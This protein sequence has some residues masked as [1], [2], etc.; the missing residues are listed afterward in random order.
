MS[1][2]KQTAIAWAMV[3]AWAGFIFYMSAQSGSEL[4][5]LDGILGEIKQW[6]E[7][8]QLALFGPDADLISSTAHFLE[9]TVLGALL[10]RAIGLS[11]RATRVGEHDG[12]RGADSSGTPSGERIVNPDETLR[13]GAKGKHSVWKLICLAVA[14]ASLYGI[15]DEIHQIFVPGRFCDPLDWM[16]DTAGALLGAATMAKACEGK[17][18]RHE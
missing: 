17:R 13:D 5:S 14:I 8:V 2:T 6:V 1:L 12:K 9:Y 18:K 11:A 4:S 3:V 7:G 16:T 15:T 10:V